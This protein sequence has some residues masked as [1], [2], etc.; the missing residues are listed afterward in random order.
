MQPIHAKKSALEQLQALFYGEQDWLANAANLSAFIFERHSGLNWVGVY[1]L[2]GGE[3]VL[4][5]FQ[6]K[7]ACT[8]IALSRGVC[9]LAATTRRTQAVPDVQA[10]PGHIACDPA[11]RSE[12]VVPLVKEG[13]L[14]GVLDLDSPKP[15]H[16]SERLKKEVEA[17]AALYL[18]A[19]EFPNGP[20]PW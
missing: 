3:L 19:S 1:F 9:G 13:R 16:F 4:G 14:L 7:V 17:W 6:G 8:R 18:E 20:G 2:R 12:F 10:F 5:P 11:S 15:G